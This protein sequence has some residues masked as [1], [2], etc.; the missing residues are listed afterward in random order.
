[1]CQRGVLDPIPRT[2]H[3]PITITIRS[4]VTATHCPFRRRFNLEKANWP[5]FTNEIDQ[6]IANIPAHPNHYDDFVDL[7]KQA[8][9]HNIPR[10]CQK[11]YIPGLSDW[12][13]DLLKLYDEEYNK[14]PFSESTIQL[15]DTLLDEISGERR[16]IWR[17]MVENTNLTMNS[18]KAW[19]TIRRLGAD[20][21]FPPVVTTVTAD[22]IANQLLS[23]GRRVEHRRPPGEHHKTIVPS[24]NQPPTELTKPFS[25][26]ELATG[27]SLLK[28]G[29]AA[30][31]NDVLTEMLQHLG[32]KA[33]SW[34]LDMLNEC[35]AQSISHLS[36]GKQREYPYQS[37]GR[38]PPPQ[39]ATAQSRYCA[40]RIRTTDTDAHTP[41]CR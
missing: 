5:K 11:E 3:R 12:S 27:L 35:N 36:G 30:G 10:G 14:D 33:K 7:V 31:L 8:A 16:K 4:P 22:Q 26:D 20:N 19:A 41:P 1:M 25:L 21:V 37:L 13:S 29:K 23:N 32:N 28:P 9:R 24:N 18:K 34:L 17:D 6:A 2:Q 39:K 40:L 15:G 38:I